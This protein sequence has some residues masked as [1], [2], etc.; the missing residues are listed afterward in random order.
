MAAISA[1]QYLGMTVSGTTA[2]RDTDRIESESDDSDD[3]VLLVDLIKH[4]QAS[5]PDAPVTPPS[6]KMSLKRTKTINYIRSSSMITELSVGTAV[7]EEAA[8]A[9][10]AAKSGNSRKKAPVRQKNRRCLQSKQGDNLSRSKVASSKKRPKLARVQGSE[11]LDDDEKM[12]MASATAAL[13]SAKNSAIEAGVLAG[14]A[15]FQQLDASEW[16]LDYT[17][18]RELQQLYCFENMNKCGPVPF[19]LSRE[20]MNILTTGAKVPTNNRS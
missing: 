8:K 17:V 10:G 13:K 5:H 1:V 18:G 7:V 11:H 6:S 12:R 19:Q 15:K 9:L 20:S 2:S 14:C 3:D 16:F 4:T